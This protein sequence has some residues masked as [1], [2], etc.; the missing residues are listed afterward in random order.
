[1]H[2]W[3][4]WWIFV[5]I[6]IATV[7]VF[8]LYSTLI[9][10][11]GYGDQKTIPCKVGQCIMTSD[12]NQ[13]ICPPADNPNQVMVPN[14]KYAQCVDSLTCPTEG[15]KYA[16]HADGSALTNT[17]DKP[18]CSC[19]LYKRCP[20]YVTTVFKQLGSGERIS[21]FQAIDPLYK[22]KATDE[23]PFVENPYSPPY[24]INNDTDQCFLPQSQVT[25]IYPALKVMD[26][27]Y[28]GIFAEIK[29]KPYTFACV[30]D[31]YVNSSGIFDD[32]KFY[33]DYIIPK[34]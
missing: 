6:V 19:S 10:L 24:I 8:L 21:Y 13:K 23:G 11:Q 9:L 3:T 33:S 18:G 1:M 7:A 4:G 26:K 22:N 32:T 20:P 25:L 15:V 17:C 12:G 27:C 5:G 30:P 34:P 29:S 16:I 14:Y 28:L 31:A 2:R